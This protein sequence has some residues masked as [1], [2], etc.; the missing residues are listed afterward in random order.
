M[1]SNLGTSVI[2]QMASEGKSKGGDQTPRSRMCSSVISA[3]VPQPHQR[4]RGF[5]RRLG[6]ADVLNIGDLLVKN[7]VEKPLAANGN[8]LKPDAAR[9]ARVPADHG[10]FDPENGA[11][12][13]A[14]A[15][16]ES[17]QGRVTEHMLSNR[18]EGKRASRF[19]LKDGRSW[20]S[21]SR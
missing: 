14:R 6:K 8:A 20:S 17:D 10:G 13:M 12:P 18:E 21:A 7:M 2:T 3:G 4:H 5:S 1:T 16:Q 19:D 11:R 9:S 15:H